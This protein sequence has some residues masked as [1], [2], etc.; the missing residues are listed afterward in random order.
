M[1]K[2]YIRSSDDLAVVISLVT[3]VSILLSA[4]VGIWIWSTV[5]AEGGVTSL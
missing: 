4:L 3:A 2:R 1:N 5:A